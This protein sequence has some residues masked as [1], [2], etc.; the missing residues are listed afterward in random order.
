MVKICGLAQTVQALLKWNP[1]DNTCHKVS[2]SGHG[3][4]PAT[5]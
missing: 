5:I 1:V 2:E 3:S 4:L